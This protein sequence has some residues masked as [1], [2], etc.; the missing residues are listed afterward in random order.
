VNCY[1]PP[2][3][4]RKRS[5]TVLLVDHSRESRI[6]T[7]HHLRSNG[8]TVREA[9]STSEARTCLE[10][11]T[12]DAV[13]LAMGLADNGSEALIREIRQSPRLRSVPI[14]AVSSPQ[15]GKPCPDPIKMGAHDCIDIPVNLDLLLAKLETHRHYRDTLRRL[16]RDNQILARL[17]AF[18]DLTGLHNRRA[19]GEALT[20]EISQAAESS[21]SIA[22]LLI[23]IDHFKTINDRYG[24]LAGDQALKQAARHL[25]T[26]LR[27]SDLIGR[28][29]GEEFCAIVSGIDRHAITM[30][31]ER[32]RKSVERLLIET[33][34]GTFSVT[35]SVGICWQEPST[36]G[37]DEAMLHQADKALY[38]A[39]ARGRNQVQLREFTR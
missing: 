4:P 25:Q 16:E 26:A 27:E 15:T 18:D 3:V 32:L 19:F 29:G 36:E 17:A 30:I 1:Q 24:H 34:G 8:Y 20:L 5:Q 13:I 9:P 35:V 39:K 7:G 10:Q 6:S 28:W 23:D 11:G 37:S 33:D 38:E 2:S 14:L 12:T 31:A 21:Q 22:V